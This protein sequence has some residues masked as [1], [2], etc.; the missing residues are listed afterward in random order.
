MLFER[1]KLKVKIKNKYAIKLT[2]ARGMHPLGST[3]KPGKLPADTSRELRLRMIQILIVST[4]P[5]IR[6]F[7]FDQRRWQR[8]LSRR[9]SIGASHFI[10]PSEHFSLKSY[11]R[12]PRWLAQATKLPCQQMANTLPSTAHSSLGFKRCS[13]FRSYR[14]SLSSPEGI[15]YPAF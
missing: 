10:R 15:K 12:T 4:Q 11:T 13:K 2:K 14:V 3:T 7:A 1:W 9:W 8:K 6:V 5:M